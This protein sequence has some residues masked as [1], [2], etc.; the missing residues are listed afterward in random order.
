MVT[1]QWPDIGS[2]LAYVRPCT[3]GKIFKGKPC[4]GFE[5]CRQCVCVCVRAR[6]SSLQLLRSLT[7]SQVILAVTHLG[8]AQFGTCSDYQIL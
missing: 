7:I 4:R 6:Q 8:E 3:S 1:A 2:N 5:L